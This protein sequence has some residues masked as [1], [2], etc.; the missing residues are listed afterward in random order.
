MRIALPHH[1]LSFDPST[2]W[3]ADEM[4]PKAV[5]SFGIYLRSSEHGVYVNVRAQ[6]AGG[7]PLTAEGLLALLR[8]QN[9]ASAP[10]NEWT[11]TAGPLTIVGG[12]FETVGMGGEVVLEVFVTDGR[13][14]ANLAGPGERAVIAAVMPSVQ[15][16]AGSL[17]FE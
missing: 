7:H 2:E 16:L 12:T 5:E 3:V 15:R 6:E 14:V 9:W 8:E 11:V 13:S 4:D 17:W 10:F 1:H